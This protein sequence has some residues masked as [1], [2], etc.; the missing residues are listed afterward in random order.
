MSSLERT[1][2]EQSLHL[3]LASFTQV[4]DWVWNGDDTVPKN[5][6]VSLQLQYMH[7][8]YVYIFI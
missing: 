6:I 3:L 4:M 2:E 1:S 5:W 8:V 7:S